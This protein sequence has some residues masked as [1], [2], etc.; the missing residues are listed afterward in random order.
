MIIEVKRRDHVQRMTYDEF[1]ARIQDGEIAADTPVRFDAVTGDEFLAAGELELYRALADPHQIQFRKNLTD[2]GVPIATALLVGFQ[3]RVYLWAWVPGA[4]TW[5]QEHFTNWAPAVLED[6]EVYRLFTYGLLHLGFTHVLFNLLFLAYTGWNLERAIGRANLVLV[7]FGSVFAGGLLSMTMA[8]ERPSLGASGGNFGLLAAAGV[9]GWKQWDAIP[10]RARKYF[11]YALVPYIAVSFATGLQAENVDNWGHLGGLLGGMGLML[12]LEPEALV[13]RA[14]RNG[15]VRRIA[16]LAMAVACAVLFAAGPR[17]VP[18]TPQEDE[19]WTVARPSYWRQGWTF[20]GDRGWFAPT[21]KATLV[22]ATTVEPR[23]VTLDEAVASV[24]LRIGSGGK[25][26]V[27]EST[28]DL[29]IAGWPARRVTLTFDLS[30]EP[31]RVTALVLSRGV[32]EH[33]IQFQALAEDAGRYQPLARRIIDSVSVQEPE[34]LTTALE[35]TTTSPQSWGAWTELGEQHYRNG[36]PEDALHAYER[37][38]DL[39]PDAPRVWVGLLRVSADY[40]LS[41][42]TDL[43]RQALA[44]FSSE[45]TVV[46]AAA[47]ALS[48]QNHRDEGIQALEQAWT[49]RPGDNVLR[50]ARLQ[51]GL[52]V[53]MP[54]RTE[55]DPGA[56]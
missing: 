48:A 20:T 8:P 9:V 50:R 56:P 21:G 43:A 16:V 35:R 45:P 32:Y 15:S 33:R 41:G 31:Q 37:A 18:L 54:P 46:V 5:L 23:P 36:S 40:G 51:W 52:S 2:V 29:T 34:E 49:A 14:E 25:S 47:E 55:D 24:V 30:G 22:V 39:A 12:F 44:R 4:D 26:P 38:R 53:E 19:A 28:E 1:E 7:Y 11:G 17:L 42:A 3:I 10:R 6:G 27:V 13:E